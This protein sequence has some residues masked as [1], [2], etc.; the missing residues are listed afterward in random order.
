MNSKFYALICLAAVLLAAGCKKKEKETPTL[1][2]EI[3]FVRIPAFVKTGDSFHIKVSG[4]YRK[5]GSTLVGYR[6]YDPLTNKYDT[7]RLENEEGPAEFDYV[8]SKDTVGAFSLS[9]YA[10]ADGYYGI[11]QY[12]RFEVVDSSFGEGGSLGGHPFGAELTES[13]TDPRDGQVYYTVNAGG[14][15]WTA[16]NMA[17]AGSD[18]TLGTPY[19]D[20]DAASYIFG[21]FY[22]LEQAS[23]VCPTGW[24]LPSDADFAALA[25]GG[26]PK[27]KI[28]SAAAALK[29]DLSFNGLKLWPYYSSSVKITNESLFT[30]IPAGYM[31]L[32]GERTDFKDYGERAAFWTSDAQDASRNIVRYLSYDSD[33]L[34][35]EAMGGGFGASVRCVKD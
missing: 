30:A 4:A 18:G 7:L 5:D 33:D 34:Y 11:N 15:T 22:T 10:F 20:A 13:F 28:A 32:S 1:S 3:E 14:K 27:E 17:Y 19:K 29:G 23:S 16:Q 31:V 8:I 21:R 25:G 24:H 2:G 35:A 6:Y 9:I 26:N 12:S